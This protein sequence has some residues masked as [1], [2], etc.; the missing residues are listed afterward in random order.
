MLTRKDLEDRIEANKEFQKWFDWTTALWHKYEATGIEIP[1]PLLCAV[2]DREALEQTHAWLVDREKR[3]AAATPV[4][5]TQ[6]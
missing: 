3:D 6:V 2:G 5:E 1:S 4:E